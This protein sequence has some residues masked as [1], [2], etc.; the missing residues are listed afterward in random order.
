M[1][2]YSLRFEAKPDSK[3]YHSQR[4]LCLLEETPTP[5]E[6]VKKACDRAGGAYEW[7]G[8]DKLSDPPPGRRVSFAPEPLRKR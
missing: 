8:F 4:Y 2:K 1:P 6:A 7:I 5:L 3:E